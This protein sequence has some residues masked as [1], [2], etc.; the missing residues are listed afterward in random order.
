[1][2]VFSRI[3]H[4]ITTVFGVGVCFQG[5]FFLLDVSQTQVEQARVSGNH[6]MNLQLAACAHPSAVMSV[7]AAY[8]RKTLCVVF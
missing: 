3:F 8:F 4:S 2:I 7:T 6:S 1:M 5:T